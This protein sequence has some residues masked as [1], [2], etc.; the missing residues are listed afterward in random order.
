MNTKQNLKFQQ[1][2]RNIRDV[3]TELFQKEP[4]EKIT[5]SQICSLCHINRSSF[6]LHYKDV[7]DLMDAVEREM[8]S[9][10]TMIFME[11]TPLDLRKRFAKLFTFI[12]DNDAFYRAYLNAAGSSHVI[13]GLIPDSARTSLETVTRK[14]GIHSEQELHYHQAFFV[15]GLTALIREWLNRDCPESP[16]ELARILHN[17][18]SHHFA[19][20]TVIDHSQTS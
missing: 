7:Y 13:S 2:E 3:F 5:V 1:T 11:D 9:Y 17:E 12:R 4:L 20:L 16:E 10:F 8:S 15:A 14:L 19:W 6:Y 18:Y